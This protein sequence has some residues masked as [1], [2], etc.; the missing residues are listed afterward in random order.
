MRFRAL[1]LPPFALLAGCMAPAARQEPAPDPVVNELRAEVAALRGEIRSLSATARSDAHAVAPEPRQQ[2]QTALD[3]LVA[4]NRAFVAGT[5]RSGD[6]SPSRR[7][8]LAAGQKPYAAVVACADSRCPPEHLFSAGLGDVFVL[9]NAGNVANSDAIASIEY[10]V[11]HL[12]VRLI[13]VVGHEHCGAVKAAAAGAKDTP[14]ITSLVQKITPAVQA[15]QAEGGNA[16]AVVARAVQL[17]AQRQ[18]EAIL[19]GSALLRGLHDAGQVRI[20]AGEQ[21]LNAGTVAWID[22][23]GLDVVTPSSGPAPARS[24]P[25]AAPAHAGHGH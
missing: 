4:G 22:A 24:E 16:A 15:A 9:R 2:P 25:A 3:L 5:G 17:N 1:L 8:R 18:R 23:D 21:A 20:I 14:A 19:G 13:A 11:A 6:A 10:A 12:G 7:Q